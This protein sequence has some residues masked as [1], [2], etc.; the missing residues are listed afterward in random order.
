M[1][2]SVGVGGLIIGISMLVV[3]SMAVTSLNSQTATSLEAIESAHTPE[4]ILTIDNA[5]FRDVIDTVDIV[6]GGTGGY[7]NGFLTS[8]DCPDFEASFTAVGGVIT[9]VD[10]I[11]NRGIC[12]TLAPTLTVFNQ[13]GSNG[14]ATFTGNVIPYL[15]VNVTNSGTETLSTT[16]SWIFFDGSSPTTIQ[17]NAPQ[18]NP[19]I[20]IDN[21]FSGQ[22]IALICDNCDATYERLSLTV[23]ETSVS[24]TIETN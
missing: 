4:P 21:W 5:L 24:R 12:T 10:S 23:G 16:E 20:R 15:Y 7:V 14:D 8:P 11:G 9:S 17:S 19:P 22:T 3:F 13:P 2:A 1:G 6:S 18:F